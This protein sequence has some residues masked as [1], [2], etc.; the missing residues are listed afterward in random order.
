[1]KKLSIVILALFAL[2]CSNQRVDTKNARQD[3]RSQEIQIVSDV[4]IIEKALAIGDSIT[5]TFIVT[6][7]D[8]KV[9]WIKKD[10]GDI[11]VTGLP[12]NEENIASGKEKNIYEAYFYNSQNDIKS[13]ANVQFLE[14]NHFVLYTSSMKVEGKE[15]GMWSIKI[16]K[17]T[18]V[19]SVAN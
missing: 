16:P 11:Q 9:I 5:S 7:E 3:M 17:K 6:L 13:P 4:Q 8:G 12:Y 15:V 2:N 19:L 1:M 10:L 14:D 18:I